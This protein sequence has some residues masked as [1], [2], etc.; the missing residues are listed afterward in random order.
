MKHSA[1]LPLTIR[2][3]VG[4]RDVYPVGYIDVLHTHERCQLL[5]ALAGVMT[6]VT[7]ITSYVLPPNRGIWIPAHTP[8][9]IACLEELAFNALY[10]DPAVSRPAE[11]CLVFDVPPLLG[12]LID[13]VLSFEHAYDEE[14]REGR[15]VALMLDEVAR[16]PV[17]AVSAP[18]PRDPRM[19]RVCDQIVADPADPRDLD[20][21]A[22]L[23]GMGRRTFTRGFR[24]ETGLAF[25]M[26]R[27]Q[28]RL[29]TALS[30]LR[31]GKPITTI[32]YQ[33][34][35]ENPSAFTAMFHRVLGAAPTRYASENREWPGSA[36][37]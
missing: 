23:A 10:I 19:R 28:I 37:R 2:P 16:L 11:S 4:L 24:R 18:M 35:Y 6:V 22:R 7:D 33:V 20:A 15:I 9:Q 34:G 27:Q 13:E 12:A 8:H 17:L 36:H 1:D 14:G 3:V 5:Y 25:A 32:A 29:Q 26:W 30:L 21:F 31:E